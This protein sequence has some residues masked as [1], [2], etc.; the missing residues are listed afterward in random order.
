MQGVGQAG[1]VPIVYDNL[2][3]G[4]RM[5]RQVGPFLARRPERSRSPWRGDASAS[6]EAVVDFARPGL[7]RRLDEGTD[8]IL[9]R[10]CRRHDYPAFEA[11]RT[12]YPDRSSSPAPAPPMAC[13][14]ACRSSR[15]WRRIRSTPRPIKR[16]AEDLRDACAAT[17][18]ARSLRFNASRRRSRRPA[19]R[20]YDRTSSNPIGA[21]D[22]ARL[23]PR[24]PFSA[25]TTLRPTE[26]ACAT[27]ST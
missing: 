5:G 18:W 19:R 11:M 3:T 17:A 7:R 14:R 23:R 26:P 27:T 1:H 15:P 21:A 24:S 6:A 4:Q 13:L 12:R 8:A 9:S 20:G 22:G 2:H 25:P 10:Q 16:M